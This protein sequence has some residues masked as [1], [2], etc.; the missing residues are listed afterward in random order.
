MTC[1]VEL[2]CYCA[3]PI[4]FDAEDIVRG[5]ADDDIILCD[6]CEKKFHPKCVSYGVDFSF[7]CS[8]CEIEDI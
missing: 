8:D 5:E 3:M 4:H 7:I 2:I 6:L 1:S